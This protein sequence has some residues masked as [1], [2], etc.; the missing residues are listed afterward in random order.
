MRFS[1]DWM[2]T[3][4]DIA[5]G[6]GVSPSL[7]SR[8]LTGTASDIGASAETVRRILEEAARLNYR[9]NAAALTLRGTSTKTIGVIIKN[10]EDPFFGHLIGELQ[11]LAWSEQYSLVLTGCPPAKD[12]KVDTAALLK[13]QLDG[14]IVAGSDFEPQGLDAFL[15]KGIPI[16]QI[17]N[18][19]R[20]E[21]LVRIA[22]D[23]GF[24][25]EQLVAYLEKLG[26][27]DIG[28]IGDD[29]PSN[30]RREAI[31]REVL[32]NHNLR[33]RPNAIVRVPAHDVATGYEAM[34]RLL[35]QCGELLP[36][37]VIAADDVIAQTALRAL[38]EKR[39][40]VPD[41]LSLAGV[42]DIPSARLTVPALT[43][44]RQPI[45]EM[46]GEAFY[47]VTSRPGKAKEQVD[48][49][50][51]IQPELMVRESCAAPR[52]QGKINL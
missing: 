19:S 26:H 8:V 49:E 48:G 13:Y 18:G 32:Q 9:P 20:R 43:T 15:A 28:Y 24:G 11:G 7:V 17:G 2:I 21:G 22:M 36:T 51:V 3:Q 25:L 41:D 1:C 12:Q 44:L 50:I 47:L 10:F 4:K 6:L 40:R 30:L 37:A 16:V 45:R 52:A 14:V 31:V 5:R 46:V 38:F 27:R 23:Q 34:Q 29:T 35:R 39:I 42:D 33:V